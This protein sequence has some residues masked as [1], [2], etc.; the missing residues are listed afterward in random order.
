M[1]TI[2]LPFITDKSSSDVIHSLQRKYSPVVRM[3]YVKSMTDWKEIDIRS[4]CRDRCIENDSW[5]LQSSVKDGITLASTD[6]ATKRSG[7]IFGGRK[8]FKDLSIGKISNSDWK[9]SR[10]LPDRK[11]V[12]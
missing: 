8:N 12:V 6:K 11:S 10:I 3:S 2:K 4:Y 7:R 9:E 5:F 1:L